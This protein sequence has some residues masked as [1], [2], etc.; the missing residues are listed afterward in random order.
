MVCSTPLKIVA[1]PFRVSLVIDSESPGNLE[2]DGIRPFAII[3]S[4]KSRK[5]ACKIKPNF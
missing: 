1:G 4:K 2:K 3:S 5:A